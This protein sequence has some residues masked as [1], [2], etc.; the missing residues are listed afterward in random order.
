MNIH[1]VIQNWENIAPILS[2][3]KNKKEFQLLVEN[4]DVV[5]DAGGAD[6]H[7]PLASLA[8]YLGE[9]VSAYEAKKVPPPQPVSG[10]QMFKS[11]MKQHG[12]TQSDFPE[13]GSQGVVSELQDDSKRRQLTV[14]HIQ[15]LSARFKI[16]PM[17]FMNFEIRE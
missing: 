3:P 8:D 6:E 7:H 2:L 5:L 4:L 10:K 17:V 1:Q 16:N 14:A 9:L 13:I 12:L 15:A 11:L